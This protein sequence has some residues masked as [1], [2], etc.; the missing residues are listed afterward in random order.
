MALGYEIGSI[1]K[2]TSMLCTDGKT[3]VKLD[4]I[5]GMKQRF[6]QVCC[7]IHDLSACLC[8]AS[9]RALHMVSHCVQL[10]S[11]HATLSRIVL[12]CLHWHDAHALTWHASKLGSCTMSLVAASL[13]VQGKDRDVVGEIGRR[14]GLEG[15]Y[16]PRSYIEQVGAWCCMLEGACY[17]NLVLEFLRHPGCLPSKRMIASDPGMLIASQ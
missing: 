14:L 13:Q 5:E 8:R 6:V 7:W 15:T 3:S 12:N 16:I 17:E 1:M 9:G 4:T 2:R 11:A 10:P